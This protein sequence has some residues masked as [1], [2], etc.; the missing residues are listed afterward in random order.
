[1]S[2]RDQ[3]S[4]P[5]EPAVSAPDTQEAMPPT[6]LASPST[7]ASQAK[8]SST[9]SSFDLSRYL[10]IGQWLIIVVTIA[11]FVTT[12]I[13]QAFRIPSE[14]MENT[15][16]IGD[17]LLVDKAHFG[18]SSP[19]EF[20]MPY[21]RIGRE[22]IVVFRYPEHPSE[23]FVKR[24]IGVPGDRIKIV[25]RQVYI[26]GKPLLEPYVVSK[27]PYPDTYRDNFPAGNRASAH[28][29]NRWYRELDRLVEDGELIVP[30]NCYF[31][32]GDNRDQSL[33]SRYWGFVPRENI[34]G[35]PLV[36]YFSLAGADSDSDDDDDEPKAQDDRL[37]NV[38][39]D[40]SRAVRSVRWR[41]LFHFI[42]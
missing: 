5:V 9:K 4:R 27:E 23:Y 16:L 22:D 39:S 6:D 14:S 10:A 12:F 33:D 26:N 32:M 25:R 8:S 20:F 2:E 13:V 37:L 19:V 7:P 28:I 24:V 38:R 21:K 34:I 3:E 18:P 11:V 31:V 29:S 1:M 40:I 42:H 15:L 36:I 41:R 17:Y 30:A 35:R